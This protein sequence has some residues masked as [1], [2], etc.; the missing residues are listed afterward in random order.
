[1]TMA[2]GSSPK[3]PSAPSKAAQA[4]RLR[5]IGLT[6]KQVA[7]VLGVPLPSA[8]RLISEGKRGTGEAVS[9]DAPNVE[10]GVQLL[11]SVPV[12]TRRCR[13]RHCIERF[14]PVN[15]Q[16]WYHEPA[17]RESA[18][19]WS[20]E[21]IL[22]E[23]GSLSAGSHPLEMVKRAF[24][25]SEESQTPVFVHMTTRVCHVKAMVIVE[26][27]RIEHRAKK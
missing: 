10:S 9:H 19:L 4:L 7:A 6:N 18:D 22:R 2:A 20:P 3:P 16:H 23:E 14:V 12:F 21:D 25:L 24:D 5:S 8:R 17:C 1:M 13:N 27:D 15:D 26:G 11:G